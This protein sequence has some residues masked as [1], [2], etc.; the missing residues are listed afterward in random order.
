MELIKKF[1]LQQLSD[2]NW[3]NN[4]KEKC[5]LKSTIFAVLKREISTYKLLHE[6]KVK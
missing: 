1:E 3:F 6:I 2:H 4:I 5:N